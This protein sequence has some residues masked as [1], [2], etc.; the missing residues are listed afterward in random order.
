MSSAAMDLSAV[1]KLKRFLQAHAVEGS[2]EVDPAAMTPDA[3]TRCYFRVPWRT[4]MTAVAAVYPEPFDPEVQPFLDV[5][6]LFTAAQIP[7]PEIYLVDGASGII[8]QE[9]LGD[10]QLVKLNERVHAVQRVALMAQ[11]IGI[12]ADIQAATRLAYARDSIA[13]RL[14]FD[15]A[16]LMW[17]L[18]FFVEHYFTSLRREKLRRAESAELMVELNDVAATLAARPRVLCHRDYHTA[19]L[20][21]D[22]SERIRVVDY[23]DARMGASTYDLVS[24]LLDRLTEPPAGDDI[25][26][27]Q[28]FFLDERTRRGLAKLDP[29]EFA[30]EFRLMTVQRCLKAVG[31]FA[32]QT[33]N[34]NRAAAYARFIRPMLIIVIEAAGQLGRFPIL[35]KILEARVNEEIAAR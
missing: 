28:S 3:S 11:A 17:E 19:N 32:N 35:R 26:Q 13:C 22:H 24:L 12:I 21:V 29:D 30:A 6:N 14:A 27:Q 2:P 31:T 7:V 20:M 16:K 23:Q 18:E 33:A 4:N 15:E 8:I 5:T 34:F 1:E 10:D 25:K 9:D